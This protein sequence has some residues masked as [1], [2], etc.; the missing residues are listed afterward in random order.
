MKEPT[1]IGN[2]SGKKMD[3]LLDAGCVTN[4]APA[5]ASKLPDIMNR[6]C[7][8]LLKPWVSRYFTRSVRTGQTVTL[9]DKANGHTYR[10]K[11]MRASAVLVLEIYENNH[12][13]TDGVQA[14]YLVDWGMLRVVAGESVVAA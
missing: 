9:V 12:R 14:I 11:K 2:M 6:L 8:S 10:V 4:C 13:P 3:V 5:I 1:E 7:Q